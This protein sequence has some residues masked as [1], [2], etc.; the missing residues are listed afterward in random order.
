MFNTTTK[1]YAVNNDMNDVVAYYCGGKKPIV[2]LLVS[3][4]S[5]RKYFDGE[6]VVCLGRTSLKYIP[7]LLKSKEFTIKIVPNS[8]NDHTVRQHWATRWTA[9]SMVEGDR[10]LHPD[11]DT[12]YTDCLDQL[13]DNIH[14]DHEYMTTFHSVN[15]GVPYPEWEGHVKEYKKI[16]PNFNE[17]TPFYIE[18]GLLGWRGAWP[19]CLETSEA[20]KIAKDD[21]TAM[22]YVLMKHGRKAYCPTS[23]PTLMRRSRAYYR[24]SEEE[25][26]S[27][28]VWHTTPSYFMWWEV[29][30]EAY[31]NNWLGLAE[32]KYLPKISKRCANIWRNAITGREKLPINHAPWAR[33]YQQ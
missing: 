9:M 23:G 17:S 5:L 21:Q 11:C 29:F 7:N 8:E 31:E 18:F 12:I 13:F 14:H 19:H 28:I 15:D 1:Q 4:Y 2:E 3:L 32:K 24:L 16:D 33:K 22:S 10:V 26:N 30:R 6:I 25:Y 27:T 20:S